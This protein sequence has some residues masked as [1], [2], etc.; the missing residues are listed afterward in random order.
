VDQAHVEVFTAEER[1]TV[2]S[3]HFKLM[4]AVNFGNFDNRNIEGT[5]AKVIDNDGGVATRLVHTVCQCGSSWLVDDPLYIQT[6]NPTGIL[7][8]LALTVVEVSRHGDDRFGYWLAQIILGSLLHLLQHFSRDLRRRH[9]LALYFYPGVAV[10]GLENL[11][12]DQ[13]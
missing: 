1:I 2:G 9:F 5:A 6:S 3:Q 7:G 4:L 13:L 11:V 8:G 10:V 12:R